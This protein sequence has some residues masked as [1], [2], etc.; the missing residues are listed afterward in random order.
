MYWCIR[1][2]RNGIVLEADDMILGYEETEGRFYVFSQTGNIQ[3]ARQ[4][5]RSWR[6]GEKVLEFDTVEMMASFWSLAS[7]RNQKKNVLR[8]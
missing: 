3:E 7:T 6:V 4:K 5:M 8:T 1:S 2:A